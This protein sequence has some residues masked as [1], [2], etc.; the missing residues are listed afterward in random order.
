M[1][2]LCII[3]FT[4]VSVSNWRTL[5]NFLYLLVFR[6]CFFSFLLIFNPLSIKL[7]P[8]LSDSFLQFSFFICFPD[9]FSLVKDVFSSFIFLVNILLMLQCCL[10]FLLFY[11]FMRSFLNIF[12]FFHHESNLLIQPSFVLYPEAKMRCFAK[13]PV[14]LQFL[15]NFIP[16]V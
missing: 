13:V 6:Y 16:Q 5:Q 12:F 2:S 9:S 4:S 1:N 3:F 7:K 14:L 8:L 15:H 10:T 11:H